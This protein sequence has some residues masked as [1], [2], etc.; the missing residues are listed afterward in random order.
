MEQ[1]YYLCFTIEQIPDLTLA[2][3]SAFDGNGVKNVMEKHGVFLRHLYRL[4][5]TSNV[6][7]H[8]LYDYYPDVMNGR[9]LQVV[10]YATSADSTRLEHIREFVTTSVLSPY[11]EMY[12][13]EVAKELEIVRVLG[14]NDQTEECLRLVTLSG[15]EELHRLGAFDQEELALVEEGQAVCVYPPD[16]DLAPRL[17]DMPVDQW[18]RFCIDAVFPHAAYVTKKSYSLD[19]VHRP[20]DSRGTVHLYSIMEWGASDTGRLYQVLKLMEG[21]H[22]RSALRIDLF[23]I[24]N[25]QAIRK[26]LPYRE[27]KKRIYD[28]NGSGLRDYNSEYILHSWDQYTTNLMKFPQFNANIV[29][30]AETSEMAVMLADSV[31]AEAMESGTYDVRSIT[32]P[33]GMDVYYHDGFVFSEDGEELEKQGFEEDN[34][35]KTF[36]SLFTLEEIRPMFSF[37]ILYPGE[38]VEIMKETEPVQE[39]IEPTVDP[40]TNTWKECISLG[41]T[42]NGHEVTFPVELFKKH[43]FIGGVPGAGKTNTMLQLITS[44]WRDTR[45]HIPFLVL[46]PAKQEYRALAMIDGMEDLCI[47]SPGADTRFPLHI[48]PF[49]FPEGLTLNEHIQNL[50]Q[51][52]AGAFSLPMPSPHFIDTC[53]QNVYTQKGWNVSERNRGKKPY[54]TMQELFALLKE[55]VETS[56]YQ[57]E[58]LGNL[59]GVLEVRVGSLL[60]RE[61]GNV[62]NVRYSSIK[63]EEWLERPIIVEL[64]GLGEGPANFMSLLISTLIRETL[65]VRK[66]QKTDSRLPGGEPS[67][68]VKHI[69]FYEE[70]HNLIGPCK[71]NADKNNI[72]PKISATKFLV[73]MLAEVRAM[74]E[75]IVIAD[76]LPSEMAPQVMKNTCLKIGHRLT[77]IDDRKILGGTMSASED[78]LEEQGIFRVGEAL[79]FY[80]GLLKPFKMRMHEW[81]SNLPK[82]KY[83]SPTDDEL[84]ERLRN[85]AVY[86]SLLTGSA[87]IIKLKIQDAFLQLKPETVELNTYII[88]KALELDRLRT[89]AYEMNTNGEFSETSEQGLMQM[90]IKKPD[91]MVQTMLLSRAKLSENVQGIEN[92]IAFRKGQEQSW[93]RYLETKHQSLR[94]LFV[95]EAQNRIKKLYTKY[96]DLF[97]SCMTQ[98]EKYAQFRDDL[99]ICTIKFY[100]LVFKWLDVLT[101]YPELREVIWESSKDI[102]QIISENYID[103]E[104]LSKEGMLAGHKEYDAVLY[105]LFGLFDLRAMRAKDL[106][107]QVF[108]EQSSEEEMREAFRNYKDQFRELSDFADRYHEIAV[109]FIDGKEDLIEGDEFIVS[110]RLIMSAIGVLDFYSSCQK[111]LNEWNFDTE[112]IREKLYEYMD[113][114]LAKDALEDFMMPYILAFIKK[115]MES[116]FTIFG[117]K[118]RF[119]NQ[120]PGLMDHQRSVILMEMENVLQHYLHYL[121]KIGETELIGKLMLFFSR[122]FVDCVKNKTGLVPVCKELF[123]QWKDK[124][125]HQIGVSEDCLHYMQDAAA[126]YERLTSE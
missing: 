74:G 118:I 110:R 26:K 55:E 17:L 64:D 99:Y 15:R 112:N 4:G 48:N 102:L 56:P 40:V 85:N 58:A 105:R 21:Y 92:A 88:N 94:R 69:I 83:D 54:P 106:A 68:E 113:Q 22:R 6:Y 109:D 101:S 50:N 20:E 19:A 36:L 119:L 13:Y 39:Y 42:R 73:S 71:E 86:Q 25:S 124:T 16:L 61:I 89:A 84:Y 51:I 44:I 79:V 46:E 62:Y 116:F 9:R 100:C 27:T 12:C 65:K 104:H 108:K 3:Y 67:R 63:P 14:E 121:P 75:G 125:E 96:N 98:A 97:Y 45:Q 103:L 114:L 35:V 111:K 33:E 29:A 34:Y 70:A 117:G 81:E 38:T 31:A 23:P 80:E 82:T 123:L 122:S 77:A 11:Y 43:A 24:E 90:N 59:R 87:D 41:I 53:I 72:D 76:Q 49:E 115:E 47:F 60:K 52:F 5:F 95:P 2:K 91:P 126:Q 57:G 32:Q 107:N 93:G 66:M 78:Q 28:R 120:N 1:N 18:G 10:F 8:L 30:F 37:P 7:F